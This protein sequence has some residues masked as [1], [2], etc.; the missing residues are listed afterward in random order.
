MGSST[1]SVEELA[2]LLENCLVLVAVC[3]SMFSCSGWLLVCSCNIGPSGTYIHVSKLFAGV[4]LEMRMI[5]A[6]RT[7][8]W[9]FQ[10]I[11]RLMKRF[12]LNRNFHLRY[13]GYD[14]RMVAAVYTVGGWHAFR[15]K[16]H[17]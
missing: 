4:A 10:L 1:Y 6:L 2:V 14:R 5:E 11:L 7:G 15:L 13:R 3:P 16:R 9:Q 17:R 12:P 8:M